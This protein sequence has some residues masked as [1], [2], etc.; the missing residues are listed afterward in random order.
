MPI[1]TSWS[2]FLDPDSLKGPKSALIVNGFLTINNQWFI[3]NRLLVVTIT[4]DTQNG[5]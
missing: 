4:V 2:Q 5:P 3:V 1:L